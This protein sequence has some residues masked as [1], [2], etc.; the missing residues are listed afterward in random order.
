MSIRVGQGYD[1]HQLVEGR[2]LIIGGVEIPSE[3]GALGHS[4]AD[5]LIHAIM[6]GL[7]GAAGLD[8]IGH[9][10]P[11]TDKAYQGID[12]KI[13]LS[14]VATLIFEKGFK[15]GNI[16]STVCL[17]SPKIGPYVKDMKVVISGILNI[18]PDNISV[19]A[20]TGE[21]IGFVGRQEGVTAIAVVLLISE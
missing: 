3:K 7:L 10:F 9:Y 11:N 12:S 13:L 15:V 8:D 14:R 18:S 17:Q 16:D 6:D 2:P 1:V 20:T 19:K 4:N 21:E 5:V